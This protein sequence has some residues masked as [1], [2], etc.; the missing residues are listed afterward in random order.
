MGGDAACAAHEPREERGVAHSAGA[1]D[2]ACA[3]VLRAGRQLGG[4]RRESEFEVE[5]NCPPEQCA[6]APPRRGW[7]SRGGK[8]ECPRTLRVVPRCNL[9]RIIDLVCSTVLRRRRRS[10]RVGPVPAWRPLF[11]F[12]CVLARFAASSSLVVPVAPLLRCFSSRPSHALFNLLC[13]LRL[14][15]CWRY[16]CL[17]QHSC[18]SACAS[19]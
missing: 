6:R 18:C 4:C 12:G 9:A 19:G 3:H 7:A 17:N 8:S 10:K 1:P 14:L 2:Q 15:A 13:D 16:S 11:G 5:P